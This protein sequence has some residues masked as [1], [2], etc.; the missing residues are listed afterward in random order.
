MVTA[1]EE[2][3]AVAPQCDWDTPDNPIF[4]Q[5]T[6]VNVAEVIPGVALPLNATWWQAAEKPEMRKFVAGFGAS[7]LVPVYDEPYPNFI[8]F[9]HG[10]AALNMSFIMTLLSTYQVEAGSTAAAQ[11]FTADEE[12]AYTIPSAADPERARRNRARVFRTWAQLPRAV[13]AD[14]RRADE[15]AAKVGAT[16]L[17]RASSRQLWR[18]LDQAGRTSSWIAANHLLA[19]YAGSEYSSLLSQLLAA[20]LPDAPADAALRLTSA[21]DVESAEASVALWELSRWLRRQPSLREEVRKLSTSELDGAL[22]NPP[23]A[24]WRKFLARFASVISEHG[25]HGRNELSVTAADWSED[26]TFLLNS[27]RSMVDAG[28]ER[29]PVQHHRQAVATRRQLEKRYRDGLPP[30]SRREFD[31]LLERAQTFVRMRETTKTSLVRAIRPA[32]PVLLEAGRRLVEAGALSAREDVFYL[33][34]SE[35]EREM[36]HGFDVDE[37]AGLVSR[38]RKQHEQLQEFRLPDNFSGVPEAMP[39]SV[40]RRPQR[41]GRALT[42]LGVSGGVASGRA[43]VITRVEQA[44]ELPLEPGDIL[45]APLTDAPWTPLFLTAGAVVVETGGLLS[46][47]ATVAR[48]FGIPAVAMVTDATR[49]IKDGQLVTVDGDTGKVAI[50]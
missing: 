23:D 14:R 26:H 18:L 24:R 19:S 8:G 46:H 27:L 30:G 7:D 47:A 25:F 36:H 13:A 45:V 12:G 38:R 6:T 1:T 44:D 11:F 28:K 33:L 49:I 40:E 43:R 37:V 29:D 31:H 5:W 32:R 10:R 22:S 39:L 42:G 41:D 21:L 17:T 20:K 4:H 9:F 15:I 34:Y 16:D 35:F 48:E 50:D 3:V 2:R